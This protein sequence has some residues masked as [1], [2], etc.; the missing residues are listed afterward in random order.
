MPS[1]Q[2]VIFKT[3]E[4]GEPTAAAAATKPF[5]SRKCLIAWFEIYI[6]KRAL[7]FRCR[8]QPTHVASLATAECQTSKGRQNATGNTASGKHQ[9]GG[10]MRQATIPVANIKGAAVCDRQHCQWQTSMG[11]QYATGNTASGKHQRGGRMRQVTLPVANIK[12]A[13]VCDRQHCQ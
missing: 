7:F 4:E 2:R 1:A 13:A 10:S 3:S 5:K 9:R 12:G 11:R 6:R 8:A